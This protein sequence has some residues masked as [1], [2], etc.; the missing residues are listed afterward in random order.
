MKGLRDLRV[1][2]DGQRI[3]FGAGE[4]QDETWVLENFLPTLKEG[5]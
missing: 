4:I 1:H 3:V 2:P 5:E